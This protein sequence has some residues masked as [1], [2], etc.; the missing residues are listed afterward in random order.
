MHFDDTIVILSTMSPYRLFQ[1]LVLS[2]LGL[3]S[4]F[5]SF[6]QL[7][8]LRFLWLINP[9]LSLISL[10]LLLTCCRSF[11]YTRHSLFQLVYFYWCRFSNHLESHLLAWFDSQGCYLI[12]ACHVMILWI[13][14]VKGKPLALVMIVAKVKT[15]VIKNHFFE[16]NRTC[17]DLVLEI[18]LEWE[19]WLRWF[20]L[21]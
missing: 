14:H 13:F 10:M 1:C 8:V 11:W 4:N 20:S 2:T 17:I 16:V 3:R 15:R 19:P 5:T 7:Q 18:W 12:D 9:Q 6:I 21:F